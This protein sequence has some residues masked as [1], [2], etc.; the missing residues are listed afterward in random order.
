MIRL[1]VRLAVISIARSIPT[2]VLMR[3]TSSAGALS[4]Q[5]GP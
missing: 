1:A 2:P 3:H 5:P 4:R